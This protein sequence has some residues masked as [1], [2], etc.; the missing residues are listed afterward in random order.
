MW[1]ISEASPEAQKARKNKLFAELRCR[2]KKQ[3]VQ[4]DG[5]AHVPFYSLDGTL[6]EGSRAPMWLAD[7]FLEGD[8]QDW[9]IANDLIE[10]TN[11]GH[12]CIFTGVACAEYLVEKKERLRPK[13]IAMMENYLLHCLSD[14]MANDVAFVGAND[15][16]P[17]GCCTVL[18]LA[19]QYFGNE[20]LISFAKGRLADLN[21][22]LEFRGYIH[23]CN[24]PTYASVTL[25]DSSM[26]VKL[27]KDQETRALALRI[28]RQAWQEVLLHFHPLIR[29]QAGPFSRAYLDDTA[30]Q[31][32]MVVLCYYAAFG[33][34]SPYN[35]VSMLFPE[36]LEGT[37][38]HNSWDF[39]YRSLVK[40]MGPTYHPP[41]ELAEEC[42]N[43]RALPCRIEGSHE[44]FGISNAP[45]GQSNISLY[46]EKDWALGLFGSR[47]WQGQTTP[48]HLL[49][50]RRPTTEQS[51]MLEHMAAVRS[52]YTRMTVKAECDQ[53][54][55]HMKEPARELE[56]D[57]GASF[58][59]SHKGTMLLGYVPCS[60]ADP[61]VCTIRTAL[62]LPSHH[63]QPDELRFGKN[64]K[65]TGSA[66]FPNT[67]WCFVRDGDIYLGVYPLM[68]RKAP[69][70]LSEV[71][72]I[73]EGNY[74][75][76]AWYNQFGFSSAPMSLQ[77]LR[78]YG[79]GMALEIG[80][81]EEYGSFER[82]IEEISTAEISDTTY[83]TERT[84]T[85]RRKDVSLEL[86]FDYTMVNLRRALSNGKLVSECAPL[87]VEP[88]LPLAD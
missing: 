1:K 6:E 61:E 58:T 24:S 46:M 3:I 43:R 86:M 9:Q 73:F 52:V 79:S 82:F 72:F 13:A 33:E 40:I 75:M 2:Y 81:K 20:S 22:R 14:W 26:L 63:S 18:S 57:R 21:H 47:T 60:M 71:K 70:L 80:T 12:A 41:L 4:K 49:Y 37:F 17:V 53:W 38:A 54:K 77:E 39:Q 44:F 10:G 29:Q 35:P 50:R 59:V 67:D 7:L 25:Q 45:G 28:E 68:S 66:G 42:F 30:G 83:N 5:R 76:I 16:F 15:N 64:G 74:H 48:V 51:T 87:T 19:G 27:T 8:E 31:A 56:L 34:V 32:S 62:V 78:T 65:V 23:E 84:L 88:A 85:Y 55:N 11:F 36:P 69:Q